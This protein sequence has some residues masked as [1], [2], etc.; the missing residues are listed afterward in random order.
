MGHTPDEEHNKLYYSIGEVAKMFNVAPSLIRFWENEFSILKP[1]K[2]RKGNRLFTP[3]DVENLKL[4]YHLVKERGYT[5]Q[6]AKD[7]LKEKSSF[8][9]D[10]IKVIESLEKVK[11]FLLEIKEQL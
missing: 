2:N 6:G 11:A 8:E 1:H 7:R 5:L 10:N 4:I 3:K 9:R